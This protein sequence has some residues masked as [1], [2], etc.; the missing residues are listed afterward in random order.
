MC[1]CRRIHVVHINTGTCHG[2]RTNECPVTE[3]VDSIL[4]SIKLWIYVD[5]LWHVCDGRLIEPIL[6]FLMIRTK[7]IQVSLVISRE[8]AS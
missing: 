1:V 3:E 2:E 6:Q 8:V 4:N 5:T 7:L